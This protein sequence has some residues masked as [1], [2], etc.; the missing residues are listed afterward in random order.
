MRDEHA[1]SPNGYK[2]RLLSAHGS[3]LQQPTRYW[4]GMSGP[5]PKSFGP[6]LRWR[7]K[8]EEQFSVSSLPST[9]PFGSDR[10]VRQ[11]GA[12]GA[13][14][15]QNQKEFRWPLRAEDEASWRLPTHARRANM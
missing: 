3:L 1:E 11:R 10:R 2:S 5:K 12:V 4:S 9:K 8:V 14:V 15:S 7:A 6:T 13:D